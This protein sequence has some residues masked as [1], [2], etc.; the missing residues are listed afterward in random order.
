MFPLWLFTLGQLLVSDEDAEITIPFVNI[1]LML[2]GYLVPVIIGALIQR[3]C[4]RL[5]AFII[6]MLRPLFI[7]MILTMIIVGGWSNIFIVRLIRPLLVVAACLVPYT[8]FFLSGL[9]A[10]ILRQPPPRILTIAIETGIQ[11]TGLPIILMKFSLP[12][13][14]ADLSILGPVAV[15][16]CMMMPLWVAVAVVEIRRRFLPSLRVISYQGL[17]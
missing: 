15:T 14:D 12:Q 13:P 7:I 10:F 3:Y 8:G 5:K 6:R 1:I 11:N 9:V 4:E 2:T 16:M 17:K